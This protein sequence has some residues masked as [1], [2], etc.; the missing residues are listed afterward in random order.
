MLLRSWLTDAGRTL[1]EPQIRAV[2]EGFAHSGLPLW[3][4]LAFDQTRAW[5]SFDE[6]KSL[7][8][9]VQ[10]LINARLDELSRPERHGPVLVR[11]ALGY[12]AAARRGLSEDELLD[13][14]A[15]DEECWTD[16]LRRA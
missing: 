14:L 1:R 12:L 15:L 16:F 8:T 4:R 2:L 5:R 7:P 3:L 10:K 9:S 11:K 13:I 6:P